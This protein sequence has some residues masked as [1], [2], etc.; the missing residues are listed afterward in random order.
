METQSTDG[1]CDA[2]EPGMAQ[3]TTGSHKI[4]QPHPVVRAEIFRQAKKIR[5]SIRRQRPNGE[6]VTKRSIDGRLNESMGT[7][8]DGFVNRPRESYYMI[9]R[10]RAGETQ[11][12]V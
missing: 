8:I 3:V 7:V 11:V 10:L 6:L 4:G 5:R 12:Q 9:G 1:P 2:Q